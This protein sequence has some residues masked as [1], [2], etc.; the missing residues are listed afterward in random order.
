MI[1]GVVFSPFMRDMMALRFVE[2]NTS[3][4]KPP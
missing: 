3:V 2:E 1:S 4:I